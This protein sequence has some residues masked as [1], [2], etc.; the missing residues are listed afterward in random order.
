M[1]LHSLSESSFS[2][3]SFSLSRR[4]FL[5][6]S[7]A[8]LAGLMVL[9]VGHGAESKNSIRFALLSDTH[10]PSSPEVIARDTNMT[11]NLKQVVGELLRLDRKPQGVIINGDC[12]YL[13]GLPADYA[14]LAQCL[15]PIID[16]QLPLHVTMGNHDDHEPLYNALSGQ[17]PKTP[18]VGS[19]HV[20]VLETPFANLF[21]LDT[22]KA[23][24]VVTGELGKEQL[25]W[26]GQALDARADKPAIL[27]AHHT[28]QFTPPAEGKVW[29]GIADTAEFFDLI[30]SKKQVKAFIF[31]HSHRWNISERNGVHLVNLPPVAYVFS[32]DIPNGWVDA[33]VRENGINLKLHTIDP[34]HPKNLEIVN[35]TW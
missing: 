32:K 25:K 17:R 3:R 29:S 2:D 33:E 11:E 23:V 28:P 18:L 19:Q 10:I 16:A 26:L 24:N 13:K 15:Q 30:D 34:A 21:L 27:I 8:A 7:S 5:A 4:D 9:R 12:A 14:N 31:G 6:R 20:T 1:P 22:Q 35:L